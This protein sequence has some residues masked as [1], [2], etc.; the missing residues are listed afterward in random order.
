[1]RIASA[2]G[3]LLPSPASTAASQ[4]ALSSMWLLRASIAGKVPPEPGE[5]LDFAPAGDAGEHVVDAEE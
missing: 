4:F 2:D 3:D 5:I 1:M